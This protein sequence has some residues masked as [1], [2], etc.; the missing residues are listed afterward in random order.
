VIEF[1]PTYLF[2]GEDEFQK[3]EFI[4]RVTASIL[5]TESLPFNLNTYDA[6]EID[7]RVIIDTANTLPFLSKHRA[8]IVNNVESLK[9]DQI[10]LLAVYSKNPNPNTCLMLLVNKTKLPE[11]FSGLN[12]DSKRFN[13]LADEELFIW[14]KNRLK[15][16]SVDIETD[17]L[18]LII[19]LTGNNLRIISSELEKLKTYIGKR[20]SIKKEDVQNLLGIS[21]QNTAFDFIDLIFKEDS[22]G[23]LKVLNSIKTDIE[24]HPPRLIGLI[25]WNFKQILKIK[26]LLDEGK[27]DYEIFQMVKI[28]RKRV[29]DFIRQARKFNLKNL[30]RIFKLL[31]DLDLSLKRSK[32]SPQTGYELLSA[33]LLTRELI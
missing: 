5:D 10:N 25:L 8:I 14:I 7:A 3:E 22:S 31:L 26:S 24:R 20:S 19:E 15:L 32:V 9:E 28:N 13:P 29:S 27:K 1:K 16:S 11:E 21:I 17:A 33:R 4:K 18:E 2:Y 12:S 23:A 30:H 6:K